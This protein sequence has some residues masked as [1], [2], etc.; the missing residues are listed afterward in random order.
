MH[1]RKAT[2]EIRLNS[3]Y[4]MIAQSVTFAPQPGANS[5]SNYYSYSRSFC[6]Q[7]YHSR[8]LVLAIGIGHVSALTVMFMSVVT[9]VGSYDINRGSLVVLILLGQFA[10][11]IY[12]YLYSGISGGYNLMM[13]K[14]KLS[15][16][17]RR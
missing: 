3:K 5:S 7:E 6:Y 13:E 9:L 11:N 17:P 10:I 4:L 1:I 14:V 2:S 12:V 16:L 8:F 15:H